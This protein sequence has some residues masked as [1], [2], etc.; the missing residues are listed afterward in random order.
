MAT[1][2]EKPVQVRV[3]GREYTLRVRDGDAGLTREIAAYVDDR[4]RAF[5][6]AHP[7]Q[8]EVT[9]AIIAALG[10]AE[11]LFMLRQA[12]NEQ[13]ATL[14]E[15]LDELSDQLAEVAGPP[16]AEALAAASARTD[17]EA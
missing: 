12:M 5:R 2:L 1:D 15:L 3:F 6:D 4:M 11:E 9:C 13:E 10:I 16:S 17:E 14:D 7:D 8:A